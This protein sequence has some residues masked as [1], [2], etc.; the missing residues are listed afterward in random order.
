MSRT[1]IT[2]GMAFALIGC[3]TVGPNYEQPT[4]DLTPQFVLGGSAALLDG[5]ADPWWQRLND[6]LLNDL[7][8]RGAS[9]NLDVQSAIERIA[10]A[11]AALGQTGLN[12]QTD[13]SISANSQRRGVNGTT[14][15]T[16][17]LEINAGYVIDLFG[18]VARGQERAIATFHASQLDAGTIRLA[19]LADLTNS[20]I[21]AR[22]YQEA[23]AVTR[24]TIAS[25]R[26]TLSVVNQRRAVEEATELEV[27]QARS[28]LASAEAS[29]PILVA[30]FEINVFR[31]A[32][33]VAEP[34][35]PL[36]EQM[37]RGAPQPRPSGVTTVG[38]PADLLRNRPDVRAAE[39]N[40]A[41]ATA[42]VG[43]AQAQLYPSIELAG[44]LG[45]GTVDRW[46][47]GPFVSI[48]VLNR[49]ILRSR[50]RVAESA[51]R[52]AELAWRKSVLNAVEEVQT[53]MTLCRNWNL[54]IQH[55]RRAAA[56]SKAVLNLS[57]ETYALGSV[58]FAEVLDAEREY[59]RDRLTLAD[60]VRNF[61]VSWM[62]LQ[63]AT[64]RGW[65]V[66]TFRTI[67]EMQAPDLT[68]DP[69]GVEAE[70]YAGNN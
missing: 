19:Y 54:Q 37:Q 36:L 38:L 21:Q 11:N 49:G 45:I 65:S 64:G 34:A 26:Q 14:D 28:L 58:T 16:Q 3:T 41:A 39:R 43:V 61:S 23:A 32:T 59:A 35:A 13:G 8:V 70:R 5:R 25:R 27:Q 7:V 17:N 31:A 48:P 15:S 63:V 53:A 50:K 29:L 52:E 6:Q 62:Q 20:Y 18:G 4:M 40:F 9:Q 69:L 47:F 33:L 2:T 10:A 46:S 55:L 42:Q 51:A 66:E 67:S 56:S 60:A 12:A 30:N 1:L 22:Y 57:R 68:S 44:T 24:Q